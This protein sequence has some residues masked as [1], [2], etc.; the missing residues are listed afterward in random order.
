MPH[1]EADIVI[2]GV[3]LTFAQSMALRVAV[4]N[5]LMELADPESEYAEDLGSIGPLCQARL[6]E[7]QDIIVRPISETAAADGGT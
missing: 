7:V 6:S 5:M 2:N 4:S 3:P 1:K